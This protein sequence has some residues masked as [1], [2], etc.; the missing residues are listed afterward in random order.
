MTLRALKQGPVIC[1]AMWNTAIIKVIIYTCAFANVCSKSTF[2]E[3][4]ER[5]EMKLLINSQPVSC[6][7]WW[8]S[9]W[10]WRRTLVAGRATQFTLTLLFVR[11]EGLMITYCEKQN[12]RAHSFCLFIID[13]LYV[14][15]S[16]S[17]SI[18]LS[19][20][21]VC[22]LGAWPKMQTTAGAGERKTFILFYF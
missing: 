18:R 5:A 10:K 6:H 20:G 8:S 11:C 19:C 17:P 16:R 9:R 3:R 4:G 21:V 2:H 15:A 14:L 7:V 22:V 1:S 13:H 12:I